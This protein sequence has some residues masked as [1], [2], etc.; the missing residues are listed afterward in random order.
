VV[1]VAGPGPL[2]H[3][4]VM[5]RQPDAELA[6][7]VRLFRARRRWRH[8]LAMIIGAVALFLGTAVVAARLT[9]HGTPGLPSLDAGAGLYVAGTLAFSWGGAGGFTTR[10]ARWLPASLVLGGLAVLGF[11]LAALFSGEANDMFSNDN[12]GPGSRPSTRPPRSGN[13]SSTSSASGRVLA[14]ELLDRSDLE[15]W[16]GPAP[17]D[18]QTPGARIARSRS[19]A[20]WRAAPPGRSDARRQAAV[21]LTVRYSARQAARL[22]HGH[23]PAGAQAMPGLADG[24][25]VRHHDGRLAR[26]TRVRASQG[27]WVVALQLRAAAGGDDPAKQLAADVRHILNLL[28]TAGAST[29]LPTE[30]QSPHRSR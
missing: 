19:L 25:Y 8:V 27:D 2:R 7:V 20:I 14:A 9:H 29:P 30:R 26:V 1:A 16:L 15:R 17:A 5:S 4:V 3:A 11:A 22:G 13:S 18:L 10:L 23:C 24:G 6:E 12:T 21:S 28:T